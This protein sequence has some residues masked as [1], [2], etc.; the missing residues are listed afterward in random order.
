MGRRLE[1][2]RF[3]TSSRLEQTAEK[4]LE[5]I[6]RAT[7]RP[8]FFS[9]C[10]SL[11][12]HAT[13]TWWFL[14]TQPRILLLFFLFQVLFLDDVSGFGERGANLTPAIFRGPRFW[15]HLLGRAFSFFPT[16][17]LFCLPSLTSCRGLR[18]QLGLAAM[19]GGDF[20]S[21]SRVF[22]M[23]EAEKRRE[24]TILFR[25]PVVPK[26]YLLAPQAGGCV[27]STISCFC[28]TLANAVLLGLLRPV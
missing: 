26:V 21:Q 28:P 24:A 22:W 6:S 12:G 11:K 3:S 2:R 18:R 9:T 25:F 7:Q 20:A 16:F 13:R 14:R 10:R 17:R 4:R 27:F 8:A 19:G 5:G 1:N 15:T 23:L